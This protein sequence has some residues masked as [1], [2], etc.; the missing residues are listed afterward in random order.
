MKILP[1]LKEVELNATIHPNTPAQI[2]EVR[3]AA[4]LGLFKSPVDVGKSERHTVNV[5]WN[6][7]K[8]HPAY[9]YDSDVDM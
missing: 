8:V 3:R 1:A 9:F 7:D 4:L 5:H 6:T 2:A